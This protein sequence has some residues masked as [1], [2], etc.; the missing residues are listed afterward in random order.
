MKL[1]ISCKAALN[2]FN[3]VINYF[4]T[5]PDEQSVIKNGIIT[6]TDEFLN[7]FQMIG[8]IYYKQ[9]DYESAIKYYGKCIELDTNSIAALKNLS[10]ALM[11][12][13]RFDEAFKYLSKIVRLKEFCPEEF[14]YIG[15]CYNKLKDD[16]NA[17]IFFKKSAELGDKESIKILKDNNL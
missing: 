1:L 4:T 2:E 5:N 8:N 6:P 10:I 15:I 9:G 17:I 14:R 13:E 7:S 11:Y 16:R 12:Q 3:F